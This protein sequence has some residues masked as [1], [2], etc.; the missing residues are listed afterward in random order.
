M[1]KGNETGDI[2]K[3]GYRVIARASD[4]Y[5]R[6][7]RRGCGPRQTPRIFDEKDQ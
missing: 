3:D 6:D 2:R 1:N 4:D 5:R 7:M